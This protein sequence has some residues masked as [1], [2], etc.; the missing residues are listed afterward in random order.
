MTHSPLVFF[1][2]HFYYAKMEKKRA[3]PLI[4]CAQLNPRSLK[5]SCAIAS[6]AVSKLLGHLLKQSRD[7]MQRADFA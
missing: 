3:L 6:T 2:D 7:L 5:P 4:A 1:L